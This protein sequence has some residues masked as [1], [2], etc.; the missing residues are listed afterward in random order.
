MNGFVIYICWFC[1]RT[2]KWPVASDC[3]PNRICGPHYDS[4]GNMFM[5]WMQVVTPAL[6]PVPPLEPL[7]R[8]AKEKLGDEKYGDDIH[9]YLIGQVA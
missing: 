3:Q 1:G 7:R 8:W 6:S 5:S 4:T 9:Q 2:I